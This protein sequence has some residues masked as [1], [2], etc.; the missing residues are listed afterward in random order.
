LEQDVAN[1]DHVPRSS[2][3]LTEFEGPTKLFLPYND[4]LEGPRPLMPFHMK[5]TQCPLV[6][7]VRCVDFLCWV[8]KDKSILPIS[9]RPFYDFHRKDIFIDRLKASNLGIHSLEQKIK[10]YVLWLM[11]DLTPQAD[12]GTLCSTT[13]SLSSNVHFIFMWIFLQAINIEKYHLPMVD[14]QEITS[15]FTCYDP[16]RKL[17]PIRSP[18]LFDGNRYDVWVLCRAMCSTFY[19]K[20]KRDEFVQLHVFQRRFLNRYGLFIESIINSTRGW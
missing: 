16:Q 20:S 10:M 2:I 14:R 6:T 12:Y 8:Q 15:R 9:V 11:T 3:S 7:E 18:F 17:Q 1:L 19:D 4:E 13:F 5:H